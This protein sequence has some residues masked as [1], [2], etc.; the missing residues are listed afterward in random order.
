LT[1]WGRIDALTEEQIQ[2]MAEADEDTPRDLDWT[3][4]RLV[5]PAAKE[6][7]HLRID[8]DILAWFRASGKGYQTRMNAVLRTYCTAQ[9]RLGKP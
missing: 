2:A 9:M 3:A 8:R 6:S 5:V 1:D 4:A 7:I